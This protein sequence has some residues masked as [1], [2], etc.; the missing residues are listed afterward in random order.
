MTQMKISMAR[1]IPGAKIMALG[2]DGKEYVLNHRFSHRD[3][4][5]IFDTLD[6][7]RDRRVIDL[8][9]WRPARSGEC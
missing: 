2:E 5:K 8:N 6:R 7:V 1:K 3:D 9:H 4:P